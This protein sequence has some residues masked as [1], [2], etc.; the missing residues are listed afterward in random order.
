MCNSIMML[1]IS[2]YLSNEFSMAA[3]LAPV[4]RWESPVHNCQIEQIDFEKRG[5]RNLCSLGEES[6]IGDIKIGI[7]IDKILEDVKG[8]NLDSLLDGF[9]YGLH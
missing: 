7:E 1:C 2:Y 3:S 9:D 6:I 4:Y 8:M 5:C